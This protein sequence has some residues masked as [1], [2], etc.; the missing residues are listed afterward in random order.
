MIRPGKIVS[1]ETPQDI[2]LLDNQLEILF[3]N[4][5]FSSGTGSGSGTVSLSIW[6][7]STRPALPSYG[8]T[9]YNTD[10]NGLEIYT[11]NGWLVNGGYWTSATRPTSVCAG[12][13]GYN[14]TILS[15]EYWDGSEW[16]AA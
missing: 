10:R 5:N 16:N 13:W 1:L 4:Q 7:N 12:S 11:P 2:A 3:N 14:S 6:S 15:R 9:G 8:L